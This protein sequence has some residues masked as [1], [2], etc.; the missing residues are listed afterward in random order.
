MTDFDRTSTWEA[1]ARPSSFP[2][3]EQ[4]V[5]V[6]IAIVGA[7][8]TGTTLASELADAGIRVALVDA[9]SVGGN[10][11]RNS[12][13][14]LTSLMDAEYHR[15]AK[16]FSQ[17]IATIVA[18]STAA[19]IDHVEENCERFG[20]DASFMRVA[21]TYFAETVKDVDHLRKEYDAAKVAGLPVTYENE[22]RLPF[23][24]AGGIRLERQGWFNPLA[25]TQGLAETLPD[26]GVQ[27]FENTR[28]V[29]FSP[30]DRVALRTEGGPSISA[31]RVVLC[32]HTPLGFDALQT[33]L[34]PYRSYV[35]GA[36]LSDRD[37][38]PDGLFFDT[39]EPYHYYRTA[40]VDG[41]PIL[42]AG[43]ADHPTGDM[44]DPNPYRSLEAFVME[45]FPVSSIRYRWSAQVFVPADGLPYIGPS[46]LRKNVYVATGLR[47]DGLLWGTVAGIMLAKLSRGEEHP[48][49][50][51]YDSMRIKPIAAGPSFIKE[52]VDNAIHFI[53]DRF[54]HDSPQLAG[55][56]A[57]E[58]GIVDVD[59]TQTAAFRDEEGNIHLLSPICQHMKCIVKWNS[60]DRTWDC[61]CHGARYDARTGEVVSGPAMH[62]LPMLRK[63]MS[64]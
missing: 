12:T 47:G 51:A 11:T 48:W 64:E 38:Y 8:I 39:M 19:A 16:D 44:E 37:A 41:R 56:A 50:P 57:G 1:D 13:G 3:L 35:I 4:D 42:V 55:I 52:N 58:G 60:A 6:D 33:V 46:P 17:E 54:K 26:R 15:V 34:S 62:G 29:D 61:P 53:A 9:R 59:G 23:P 21:A 24:T 49:T 63:T 40:E 14:H 30:G 31:G 27:V 22:I 32:T 5:A 28:V 25:Y 7:G 45:R 43:G 20:I 2:H 18:Q 10:V 36:D